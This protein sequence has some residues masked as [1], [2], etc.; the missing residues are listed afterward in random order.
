MHVREPALWPMLTFTQ[1]TTNVRVDGFSNQLRTA[2]N[3]IEL[4]GYKVVWQREEFVN[5]DGDIIIYPYLLVLPSW[6]AGRMERMSVL[7]RMRERVGE[8]V[9]G[10]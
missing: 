7:D 10:R 2:K 4:W 9:N 1:V 3:V 6:V 5:D 8:W